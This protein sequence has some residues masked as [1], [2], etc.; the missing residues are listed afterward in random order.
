MNQE[1]KPAD[2]PNDPQIQPKEESVKELQKLVEELNV[3]APKK[4]E[5]RHVIQEVFMG[6]MER[7][8]GQKMDPETAR[9]VSESVIK[10]NDNKFHFL[11]QKQKDEAA[12][13]E[14]GHN[15]EIIKHGDR[16]KF[17]WPIV[18]VSIGIIVAGLITGVYLSVNGHETLGTGILATILAG[19][20]S[21]LA[22]L[23]TANFFKSKD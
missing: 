13:K 11:M 19:I 23:G 16:V 1:D 8:A 15:L 5:I 9:I 10:D 7:S 14:R 22:G 21:Y 6:F 20:F 4:Q 3:P 12:E 17:L 18:I 2:K